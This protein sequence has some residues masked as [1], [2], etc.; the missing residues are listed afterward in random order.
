MH[1]KYGSITNFAKDYVLYKGKYPYRWKISG[2][3]NPVHKG[4]GYSDHLPVV[5]TFIIN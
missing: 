1:Y 3:I 2:G 5:A 4:E